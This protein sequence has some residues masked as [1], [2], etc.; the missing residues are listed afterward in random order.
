MRIVMKRF[1]N[2]DKSM[3]RRLM[4]ATFRNGYMA[5]YVK[6]APE[7]WTFVALGNKQVLG[8]AMG[9]GHKGK[10][11]LNVF[12]NERFRGRGVATKLIE[13]SIKKERNI[14]LSAHSDETWYL[15]RKMKK[16]YP[17][18]VRVVNWGKWRKKMA[19]IVVERLG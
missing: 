9:F 4:Y 8:W 12:I 15:F 2:W 11:Y 18:C 5:R 6:V 7:S 13:K 19:K 17:K 1:R 16:K 10:I 14:V 3:Q